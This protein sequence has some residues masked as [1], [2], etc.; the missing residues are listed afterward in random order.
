MNVDLRLE[1]TRVQILAAPPLSLTT[2]PYK[3]ETAAFFFGVTMKTQG[4][5]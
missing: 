5:C 1:Q 2:L 3:L 4:V